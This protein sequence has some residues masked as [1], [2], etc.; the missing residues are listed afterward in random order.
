MRGAFR[1]SRAFTVYRD[2]EFRAM[3][4]GPKLKPRTGRPVGRTAG[5]EAGDNASRSRHGVGGL[6]LRTCIAP[7]RVAVWGA[8]VLGW[9]AVGVA[10]AN[11]RPCSTSSSCVCLPPRLDL[12]AMQSPELA[13]HYCPPQLVLSLSLLVSC[14]LR[15][16]GRA[17]FIV[18]R[19]AELAC[20]SGQCDGSR[21]RHLRLRGVHAIRSRRFLTAG[22][23]VS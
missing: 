10:R 21:R 2:V 6:Q 19:V 16:K 14:G 5:G 11:W 7:P 4:P 3:K 23:K 9:L 22:R 20:V 17:A 15:G 13:G 8:T 18:T 1:L 12:H